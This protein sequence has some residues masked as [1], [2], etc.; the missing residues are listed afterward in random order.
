MLLQSRFILGYSLETNNLL[1]FNMEH[2]HSIQPLSLLTII[3]TP[4]LTHTLTTHKLNR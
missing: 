4:L 3:Y 2:L 1:A